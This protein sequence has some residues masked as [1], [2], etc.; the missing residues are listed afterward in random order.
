MLTNG[1]EKRERVAVKASSRALKCMPHASAEESA[2]HQQ[3]SFR[4]QGCNFAAAT[5]ARARMSRGATTSCR[6][7]HISE[8]LLHA[9]L[10]GSSAC[11]QAIDPASLV[12]LKTQLRKQEREEERRQLENQDGE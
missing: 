4:C 7:V 8:A 1:H 3:Q 10:V 9:V 5:A 12:R 11:R 2:L 6:C